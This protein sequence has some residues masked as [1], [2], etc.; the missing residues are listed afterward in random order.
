L[1]IGQQALAQVAS[2]PT[3]EVKQL[4]Q[5]AN[6]DL[7]NQ[8]TARAVEEYR[9][10]LALD[11]NNVQAHANLGLAY[12]LQAEFGQA[13]EQFEATLQL[14]PDLWETAALCGLSEIKIGQHATAKPHLQQAFDHVQDHKLRMAVGTQLFSLLFEEGDLNDASNIVN[15]LQ[16]LDPANVDVLYAAHQVFSLL[17]NRAYLSMAQLAPN[18][19][20]MYQLRGDKMT[21]SGNLQGAIAA[22]RKAIERDSHLAGAH[23]ALAEALS[24]S[25]SAEDRS[26]AEAQYK[27]AIAEN[28]QDEKA[29]CRLGAIDL[30]RSDT[31]GATKHYQHALQIRP[32]D[33]DANEGLGMVLMAAESYQ[34]AVVYLQRAVELDPTDDVAHY[35]LA[36]VNRELGD[37]NGAN[38]EMEEF[39]KLKAEKEKLR[40]SLNEPPPGAAA[41]SQD[42]PATPQATPQGK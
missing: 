42:A 29:E 5:Q 4:E 2:D 41:G 26:Q 23:F 38:H 36:L 40:R 13:S 15:E 28:G 32:D 25:P 34:K 37:L 9:R 39:R 35:H 20:R 3:Q 12:Y 1:I 11:S 33:P 22:Y 17:E 19:A 16:D 6:A 31:S 27:E 18:S 21:L 14:K 10:I 8:K 24:K 7:Q 30:D